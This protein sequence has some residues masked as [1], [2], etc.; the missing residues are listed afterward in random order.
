MTTS[1][2]SINP[3]QHP[4]HFYRSEMPNSPLREPPIAKSTYESIFE[5]FRN[6]FLSEIGYKPKYSLEEFKKNPKYEDLINTWF[7]LSWQ[8]DRIGDDLATMLREMPGSQGRK[9]FE[10][11]LEGEIDKIQNPHPALVALSSNM[12]NIPELFDLDKV[13]RGA[14]ILSDIPA[15]SHYMSTLSQLVISTNFSSGS[16]IVAASGKLFDVKRSI[17]RMLESTKYILGDLTSPD[18]F[19]A[20][21]ESLKDAYRVRL[22]HALIRKNAMKSDNKDIY[23]F[24]NIGNPIDMLLTLQG[25][26][27]FAI[28]P[29]IMDVALGRKSN[30]VEFEC[31][32]EVGRIVSY[33]NGAEY[34]SL[35]KSLEEFT[36]CYDA[37]LST[38]DGVGEY[39]EAM[40]E[41]LFYGFP[42]ALSEGQ[43]SYLTKKVINIFGDIMSS[44]MLWSFGTTVCEASGGIR[45]GFKIKLMTGIFPLFKYSR[46]VYDF[47]NTKLYGYSSRSEKRRIFNRSL[48]TDLAKNFIMKSFNQ[49]PSLK[50]DAHDKSSEKDLISPLKNSK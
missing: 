11:V 39:S 23:D 16:R 19:Q 46:I 35:P 2:K 15:F 30:P 29:L 14:D 17:T 5:P 33:L 4:Y 9:Q 50:F 26:Y 48:Y 44:F 27:S 21:S 6:K 42:E 34:E 40:N 20:D 3:L 22:M 32:N 37:I 41:A 43:D 25:G 24:E 7:D 8:G 18:L 12:K 49:A 1:L 47:I 38:F 31:I 10:K 28:F 45:T 13:K 36:M